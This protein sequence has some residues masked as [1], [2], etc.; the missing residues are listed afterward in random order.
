[1]RT[2][3][4]MCRAVWKPTIDGMLSTMKLE[5]GYGTQHGTY[6]TTPLLGGPAS[7]I[8]TPNLHTSDHSMRRDS[9]GPTGRGR[10]SI[11]SSALD[12]PLY[13]PTSISHATRGILQR[14]DL[15][16]PPVTHAWCGNGNGD[17][18]F[19]AA[20]LPYSSKDEEI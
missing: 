10:N 1:M 4:Y 11:C 16:L 18:M 8:L 19:E 6:Y 2:I 7:S 14:Q 17:V 15:P 3:R 13:Y 5:M 9:T 20:Y 12:T